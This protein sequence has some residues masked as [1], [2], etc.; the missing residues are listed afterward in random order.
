MIQTLLKF[1]TLALLGVIVTL[2]GTI[3]VQQQQQNQIAE[4]ARLEAEG[5][6][7]KA[8]RLRRINA[9]QRVSSREMADTYTG[10]IEGRLGGKK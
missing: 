9:P 3:V 5:R 10:M 2:L 6:A 7:L 8:D 1:K 4:K